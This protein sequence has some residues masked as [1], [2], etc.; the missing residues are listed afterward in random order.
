MIDS[1]E[2]DNETKMQF[3]F[4]ENWDNFST[5]AL[6]HESLQEAH[7]AFL[8]L[9]EGIEL[10]DKR[11]LDI[12]FGQGLSLLNAGVLGAKIVGCDIN[13]RCAD[14]LL[15]NQALFPELADKKIPILVGS[16][17]DSSMIAKLRQESHGQDYDIVHSWG[18]L[19]HTGKMMSAIDNACSLVQANGFLI[20][21][22]YNKHWSSK[23]WLFIKWTYCHL[24]G[25]MQRFMIKLM[26][27]VIFAAKLFV[28]GKNPLSQN[29][30]MDFY[31]DVVDW[32]GGYPYEY[33]DPDDFIQVMNSKG[34]SCLRKIDP[35]VPTGCVEFVFQKV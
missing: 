5:D 33:I 26:Y 8:Q 21:A 23:A 12:G 11:F 25:V 1:T 7:L 9:M 14:V 16:I 29:R 2:F 34:F 22:L 10:T 19:H 17:L 15:K 6:T 35:A 20:L 27:P 32:V 31:Y 13:P 30:G 24:P 18:V 4:G 28:T 3:D